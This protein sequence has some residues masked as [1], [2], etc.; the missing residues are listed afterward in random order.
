LIR[1]VLKPPLRDKRIVRAEIGL[2]LSFSHRL[3]AL[4]GREMP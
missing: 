3:A 1:A 2:S 4:I